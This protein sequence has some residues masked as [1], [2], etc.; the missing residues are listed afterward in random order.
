MLKRWNSF[1]HSFLLRT[2]VMRKNLG[3]WIKQYPF[4]CYRKTR[5][6]PSFHWRALQQIYLLKGEPKKI[7][8]CC[9]VSQTPPATPKIAQGPLGGNLFIN[10]KPEIRSYVTLKGINRKEKK[11]TTHTKTK[12]TTSQTNTTH[13]KFIFSDFTGLLWHIAYNHQEW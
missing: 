11:P 7:S 9:S 6:L 13:R 8:S 10:Q 2:E 12:H 3:S 1:L 5:T 4:S